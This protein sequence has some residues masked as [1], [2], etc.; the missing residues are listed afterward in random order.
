M[1]TFSDKLPH[2]LPGFMNEVMSRS[3]NAVDADMLVLS[4]LTAISACLPNIEGQYAR[5]RVYPNLFLMLAAP[6][7]AGKGRIMLARRIVEPVHT[8]M[9]QIYYTKV[10]Q[11]E[12]ENK[13]KKQKQDHSSVP[14]TM[15]FIPANSSATA[16]Y[17]TLA[18]CGGS[19]LIFESEADTLA[20]A[21]STDYGN[22]SD[23]L[24]KAFHH[25]AISYN[26]R[27][28]REYVEIMNPRLS[29]LLAGTPRQL[30]NLIPSTEN[31]LFSRFLIYNPH[32]ENRWIDV[33]DGG[34]EVD[35]EQYFNSLGNRFF[36]LYNML[37]NAKHTAKFVLTLNQQK[38][39]NSTFEHW[40]DELSGFFGEQIT[41]SVRRLG[42]ITFRIAMIFTTLRLEFSGETLEIDT[43][44][45][46]DQDFE[47]AIF[48][49]ES[50]LDHLAA[51]FSQMPDSDN[52]NGRSSLLPI[53]TTF[54]QQLPANF[55]RAQ[56]V[57]VI[58]TL[59]IP[60]TTAYRYLKILIEHNKIK[61]IKH[62]SYEKN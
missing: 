47:N 42:L 27:K 55:S 17:Q 37:R 44:T 28:D 31:G 20:S 11:I 25:E 57:P 26:R 19:G 34:E 14:Q 15:L 8:L 12:E 24:R 10:H 9:R 58:E 54:Y 46:N 59:G 51:I 61:R 23:G 1:I 40:Q 39:F 33:F 16:I 21:L 30:L 29:L 6:P 18:D 4:S 32:I 2:P 62:N 13:D 41:P 48:I 35:D 56:I 43:L 38:L 36:Y 22:F 52:Q 60:A 45:C 49:V 5:R 7:S 53:I 3:Q 50:L